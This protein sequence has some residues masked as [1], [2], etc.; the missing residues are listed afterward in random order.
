MSPEAVAL[1]MRYLADHRAVTLPS[2]KARKQVYAACRT[3]H[4][5]GVSKKGRRSL[6]L[7]SW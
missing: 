3:G 1:A 6:R 7:G 4:W 2:R 5:N